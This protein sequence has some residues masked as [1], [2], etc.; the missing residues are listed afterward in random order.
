MEPVLPSGATS[1]ADHHDGS[2][3]RLDVGD[4]ADDTETGPTAAAFW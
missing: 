4:D 3:V 2:G 1:D